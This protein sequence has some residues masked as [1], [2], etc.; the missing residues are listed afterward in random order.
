[1]SVSR[2]QQTIT[3]FALCLLTAVAPVILNGQD[4]GQ[5]VGIRPELQKMREHFK[6]LPTVSKDQLARDI[7]AL[8]PGG[9][10]GSPGDLMDFVENLVQSLSGKAVPDYNA[11]WLAGD[12]DQALNPRKGSVRDVR[13]GVGDFAHGL[14][15]LGV[16][17][18]RSEEVE[19]DLRK[20]TP[21]VDMEPE[22]DAPAHKFRYALAEAPKYDRSVLVEDFE[23][24]FELYAAPPGRSRDAKFWYT[25]YWSKDTVATLD[26]RNKSGGKY[27]MTVSN[28]GPMTKRSGI[29]KFSKPNQNIKGCNALRMWVKPLAAGG[30]Q[31]AVT[32]GFIDG[33][34]EIWQLDIPDLLSGAEAYILQVRLEDFRRVVRRNNGKIDLENHDFAIWMRG[35]YKFALDDVM[36]VHDPAVP[37]FAGAGTTAK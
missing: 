4:S 25:P 10:K 27:G 19:K 28:T 14:R 6:N 8:P 7:A 24:G 3:G 11:L 1:M 33:S 22:P 5:V 37:E 2:K 13:S 15:N 12:L 21:M 17:F 26:S 23:S 9:F 35:P 31:G 34:D 36:F 18:S 30:A 16:E 29:A 20:L 32:I